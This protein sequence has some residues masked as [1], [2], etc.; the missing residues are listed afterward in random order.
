MR[1]AQLAQSR[2]K[3]D[4][5]CSAEQAAGHGVSRRT[6]AAGHEGNS[7]ALFGASD[8]NWRRVG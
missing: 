2:T 8:L 4:D 7:H 3:R 5:R 6:E 1:A